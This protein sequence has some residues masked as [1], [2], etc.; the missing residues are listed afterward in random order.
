MCT[1][2]V[3]PSIQTKL[4]LLPWN[5][6]PK[7]KS[8]LA[9]AGN[10]VLTS[11]VFHRLPASAGHGCILSLYRAFY[12]YTARLFMPII[13]SRLDFG[14]HFFQLPKNQL[15]RLQRLLQLVSYM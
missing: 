12:A 8:A 11:S 14:N 5:H 13:S 1:D 6:T 4:I 2:H 10:Y 9:E 3:I 7:Q 15:T